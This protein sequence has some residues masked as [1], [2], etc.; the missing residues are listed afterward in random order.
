MKRRD[1]VVVRWCDLD[2]PR[3]VLIPVVYLFDWEIRSE[4]SDGYA[5]VAHR[6]Q[7][8]TQ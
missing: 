6:N 2:S 8:E 5:S 1:N 3:G 4:E 7:D